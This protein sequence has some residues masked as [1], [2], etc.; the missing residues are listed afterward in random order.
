MP[1]HAHTAPTLNGTELEAL[2]EQRDAQLLHGSSRNSPRQTQR[3]GLAGSNC[4]EVKKIRTYRNITYRCS[5]VGLR[6]VWQKVK[7]PR[8]TTTVPTTT[9]TTTTVP[10]VQA[11]QEC[12][13]VGA[14]VP[15]SL[16]LLEC[17][18]TYTGQHQYIQLSTGSPT[19]NFPVPPQAPSTSAESVDECRIRD[20]RAT[21]YQPW[22]V[23]FPRGDKLGGRMLPNRGR[24]IAHLIA[25]DFTDAEGTNEE[26]VNAQAQID[27]YNRWF[28]FNSNGTLQFE[29]RYH[30]QWLRMSRPSTSYTWDKHDRASYIAHAEEMLALADPHLDFSNSDIV[31]VLLPKTIGK[32][33][34]DLGHASHTLRTN[35]GL[36]SNLWAGGWYFYQKENGV[37][38][39][40]WSFWVHEWFHPMGIPGHGL[41]LNLDV[42]NNQ[43]GKSVV[44]N[45]WDAFLSGWL[46]ASQVY[47]APINRLGSYQTKLVPMER[48]QFGLR[49]VMIPVSTTEVIVIESRRAEGWGERLGVGNYGVLVYVIDSSQD[50]DRSNES[51]VD[52]RSPFQSFATVLLP[53]ASMISSERRVEKLLVVGEK[54]DYRGYSIEFV[55]TGDNDTI[56]VSY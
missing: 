43:N 39:E 2:A 16:G 53:K 51:F 35:E 4:S 29:W 5:K 20:V 54:V 19:L 14:R 6:S 27:E 25:V 28:D 31:F 47:C 49:S 3:P 40:L 12:A 48:N 42:M 9:T 56:K 8:S 52:P 45:A 44:L 30:K 7:E 17:R 24:S 41:R 10:Q 32:H 34:P 21:T 26:L 36:V 55:A 13:R 15:N 33:A 22:N 37:V 11:G 50:V 18:T 1:S 23:A 38:R 46:S